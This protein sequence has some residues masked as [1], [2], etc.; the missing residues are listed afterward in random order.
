MRKA[1]SAFRLE[2][3]GV[4]G[5]VCLELDSFRVKSGEEGL[6]EGQFSHGDTCLRIR[7]KAVTSS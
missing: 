2:G 7:E 1:Y 5:M 6:G 3:F 4:G